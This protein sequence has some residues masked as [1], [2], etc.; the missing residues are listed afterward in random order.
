[1]LHY[2]SKMTSH[3]HTHVPGRCLLK[4]QTKVISVDSNLVQFTYSIPE[5][6]SLETVI[7][8][9]DCTVHTHMYSSMYTYYVLKHVHT[10]V[11]ITTEYNEVQHAIGV[12]R[13]SAFGGGEGGI[14]LY[15]N[16]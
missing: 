10:N 7:F 5:H 11:R 2:N 9:I 14:M 1:M 12:G 16:E 13:C 8:M 3:V 4:V 6:G 15:T